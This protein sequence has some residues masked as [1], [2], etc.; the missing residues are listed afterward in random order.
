MVPGESRSQAETGYAD[1]IRQMSGIQ[2]VIHP[3][4]QDETPRARLTFIGLAILLGFVLGT[5]TS[6][7]PTLYLVLALGGLVFVGLLLFK[8]ELAIILALFVLEI[9]R[10][11]NYLGQG[12][13]FHPNGLMGI[14]IIV[15]T[16]YFFLFNKID[17][18]RLPG[19][20]SFLAFVIIATVSLLFSG[21]YLMEGLTVTLR[22]ATA[23]S[24]FAILLY[25][26]DSIQKVKW[27][28]AAVMVPQA[29]LFL[30]RWTRISNGSL[31]SYSLDATTRLGNSGSGVVLAMM[32][33]FCT[34]MFFEARSRKNRLIWGILTAFFG[35]SLFFSFG[36]AGWIGFLIA[37]LI[38]AIVKY[39]KLLILLPISLILVILLVPA[40]TQRFADIDLG[41]LDDRNT[42]TLA[43]RIELW[44]GALQV[45]KDS[46][47]LGVG[48]GVGRYRV[49]E[50]LNQYAW[51]I[52]NDYAAVL[53][54][55]GVVGF[56]VFLYWHGQWLQKLHTVYQE[57]D[58]HW[59][60]ALAF[61]V[62]IL[63]LTSFVVRIT[64]NVIETTDKL[65]TLA[66][67]I[68]VTLALPRIR[69]N[70]ETKK[71]KVE[72]K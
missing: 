20:W 69:A 22:L 62:A 67:L 63:F 49:G 2:N 4:G 72:R 31:T 27:V 11:Y 5:L 45:F 26:I 33:S 47:V 51:A 65:F 24:I 43:H 39:R 17:F 71:T 52:H 48:F 64:D 50:Y 37:L 34:V 10:D 32:L 30:S 38:M 46:P 15:G 1:R 8:I 14:A 41:S 36:R 59:D 9:L 56:M 42:N 70:D 13:P 53:V 21:K 29:W 57:T 19:M 58:Y 68:A 35:L 28:I 66:A 55:T 25:K 60:K 54:G 7:V 12:T 40:V 23:L 61:A 16:I 3:L 6:Y 44:E 18:S